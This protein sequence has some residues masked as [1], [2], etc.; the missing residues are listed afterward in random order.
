MSEQIKQPID[1]Y[2]E[3]LKLLDTELGKTRV[4]C[5]QLVKLT[6]VIICGETAPERNKTL[7]AFMIMTSLRTTVSAIEKKCL[8]P[9]KTS[10]Q[11]V[12][13]GLLGSEELDNYTY[14]G[15]LFYPSNTPRFSVGD[16][17]VLEQHLVNKVK[18]NVPLFADPAYDKLFDEQLSGLI[19][20]C[21]SMFGNT[22]NSEMIKGH[23]EQHAVTVK[24][25]KTGED[26]VQQGP[27]PP[28]VNVFTT[29]TLNMRNKK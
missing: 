6:E 19:K 7:E 1:Q 4:K 24:D 18:Q 28:G 8:S 5:Q 16:R 14:S 10:I 15:K 3:G 2:L 9:V 21:M 22:L 23:Q 13:L 29:Q 11:N 20:E 17:E 27:P 12:I 25:P 26:V